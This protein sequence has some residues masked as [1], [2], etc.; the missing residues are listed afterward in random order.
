MKSSLVAPGCGPAHATPAL[1]RAHVSA[2]P[3]HFHGPVSVTRQTTSGEKGEYD[4]GTRLGTGTQ[5]GDAKGRR[6][7]ER[8]KQ[9]PSP[10]NSSR[11]SR[12]S[13][14]RFLT[15]SADCSKC[16]FCPIP[17]Q[18]LEESGDLG[19]KQNLATDQLC[20][21]GQ[22]TPPRGVSGDKPRS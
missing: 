9:T 8:E 10:S 3:G 22:V 14:R 2:V 5:Q 11:A 1:A 12:A 18:G 6:H 13:G 21:L 17:W 19:V 7:A 20:G 4:D 16:H 15:R